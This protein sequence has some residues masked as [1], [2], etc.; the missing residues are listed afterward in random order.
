[1]TTRHNIAAQYHQQTKYH[2][3]TIGQPTHIWDQFNPP[4]Q[5]KEYPGAERVDLRP[6]LPMPENENLQSEALL[7]DPNGPFGLPSLSRLLFAT[8]GVTAWAEYPGG[9]RQYFRAAPSA[10]ALYPTDLYLLV[11]GHADLPEGVYYFH[12]R[13][14]ALVQVYPEGLCPGGDEIFARLGRAC[15]NDAAAAEADFALVA[16]SVFWRS[17]WRYGDRGYRRCL[18]DTGHVIGNFDIVAPRLGI[19]TTAIGGF[20]D[21]EVAELLAIPEDKEGVL[22]VF[23]LHSLEQFEALEAGPSARPSA[24]DTSRNEDDA[25][26]RVHNAGAIR[27]EDGLDQPES[28]DEP[29]LVNPKYEFAEGVKLK[30]GAEDLSD[31]IEIAILRRRS[32]RVL[33][34]EPLTLEQLSDLLAFSYRPDLRAGAPYLPRYFD[35]GLIETF[36]VVNAVEGLSPGVY[37][38]AP[39]FMELL[40]VHEGSVRREIHHLSLDQNLARDASA[41]VIHT[42]DLESATARYGS[43]AYRYLHLDAGHIGQRLNVAAIRLNLGVSGIGGFFDDEVNELLGIPEKELCVYITCLGKPAE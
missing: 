6:F 41:V 18:L 42:A 25:I 26:L 14:H 15:F 31:Q 39:G 24:P 32:T 8:N 30:P 13:E 17:A 19:A 4:P 21:H 2:P 3:E 27:R 22:G 16:T 20:V 12:V 43:R 7:K 5:F 34:G 1:M 35:A 37:Y 40:K 29:F 11:R 10:G 38:F 33:N 23:P 36:V 9:Q 28:V